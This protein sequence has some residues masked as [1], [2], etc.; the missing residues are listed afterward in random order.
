[1]DAAEVIRIIESG[2]QSYFSGL[3]QEVRLNLGTTHYRRLSN[4][5]LVRRM[6]VVYRNLG[7]WLSARD[8]SAVQSAGEDLGKRRFAEGIPLGQ[9][10]LSLILEEKYLRK[11][12]SDQGVSLEGEWSRV[13][14]DYFQRMTYHT[15]RGYEVALAYSNRLAQGAAP[16]EQPPQPEAGSQPEGPEGDVQISR[17]G[18]VG[19]VAG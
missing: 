8:E 18:A 2:A 1:M 15:A 14:S 16:V 19:E 11:Y 6:A 5:E 10:V 17:G 4:E 12:F 13:V 7:F 9:V 3:V